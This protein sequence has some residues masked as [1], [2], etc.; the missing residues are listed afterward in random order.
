LQTYAP[1]P[2]GAIVSELSA[3]PETGA[4]ASDGAGALRAINSSANARYATLPGEFGEY[5]R[6]GWP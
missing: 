4:V 5:V 2:A 6:I 3:A 1:A